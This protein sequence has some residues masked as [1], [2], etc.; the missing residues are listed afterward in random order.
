VHVLVVD[1]ELSMREYLEVLLT[2]GGYRVSLA[3]SEKAASEVLGSG[4]VDVIISDMKLGAGSGLN[5]LKAARALSAPPEVILITAFGTPAAAVEAMRAGAY[6]YICKPFDNEELKLL[7]QKAMEKRG[8][9]EENRQLRRSLSGGRGGLW[10][11]ESPAMQQVWS[12]VEKV[13]P[14]RTTVLITGESGTGK[15]LVARALHLRSTRAGAPFMPVNCAAL[16]EGVLESELFGHVKG[17]FTGAQGDRAG[18]LVSAGEGTVF[19]D[20]IGEVPLST[21]VK[22]LRVLQERRVKPVGSSSEVPFHARVVAATNKRLEVE[23]KAGRFRED[24]L[25]RLNTVEIRLPA[26]RDRQDDILVLAAHFLGE[27][28]AKYGKKLL[29]FDAAAQTALQ[30]HT[31]PGNVRELAHAVER[32]VLLAHGDRITAKDL[33]LLVRETSRSE[34]EMTLEDAERAFIRKVL[35]RHEGNVMAAAD[36]LGMSRSALYRRI[37]QYG[38]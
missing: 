8:L 10:V 6:D 28:A 32:S 13:A 18:I 31:W 22:M 9:R 17:A 7:V 11:G 27:Y 12:L 24:L 19:L 29:T 30:A 2:R 14:S 34:E 37:Q 3:G 26:L 4:S 21:Q 36:Q 15:E 5:V 20:E 33:G 38:L 25:Y 16:N 35:A 23:V 1:D